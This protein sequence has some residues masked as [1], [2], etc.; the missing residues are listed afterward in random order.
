MQALFGCFH[1]VAGGSPYMGLFLLSILFLYIALK[2]K[3]EL[4]VYPNLL[5]V[6]VLFNPWI[7][8]FFGRYFL[9]GG[10]AWRIWW[11]IP[12]PF[13]IAVMF[14]K[15]LDYVKGKEK[16][17]VTLLICLIIILSGSF[18]VRTGGFGRTR[19]LYQM[20]NELLE[21]S[22]FISEDTASQELI[23]Q[24][25]VAVSAVAW[26]LRVYNPEIIMH[27]G[28]WPRGAYAWEIYEIINNNYPNFYEINSLLEEVNASHM[29]VRWQQVYDQPEWLRTPE[30]LGYKLIGSTE[31]YRIYRTNFAE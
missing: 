22:R 5:I 14:T 23:E 1:R 13:L 7:M 21:V 26:R 6:L 19:N 11:L 20:P 17:F 29:V 2:D 31:S 12:I 4:W 10:V 15:A 25:V 3:R 30:G 9:V 24:N 8:D 28:R 16:I 18:V 27:Y